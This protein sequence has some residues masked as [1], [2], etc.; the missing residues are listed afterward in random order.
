MARTGLPVAQGV[1]LGVTKKRRVEFLRRL[2]IEVQ[3]D[4][5]LVEG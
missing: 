2:T 3:L 5:G 4:V 1:G